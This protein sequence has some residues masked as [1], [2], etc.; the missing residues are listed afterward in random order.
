M[1]LLPEFTDYVRTL[2]ADAT[3]LPE[4]VRARFNLG[5]EDLSVSYQTDFDG[6]PFPKGRIFQILHNVSQYKLFPQSKALNIDYAQ[7]LLSQL[8][9]LCSDLKI[10]SKPWIISYKKLTK[11]FKPEF[12]ELCSRAGFQWNPDVYLGAARGLD[13][14]KEEDI[15]VFGSLFPSDAEVDNSNV[16]SFGSVVDYRHSD[17]Y[18]VWGKHENELVLKEI[19]SEI[20]GTSGWISKM[21]PDRGGSGRKIYSEQLIQAIRSRYMRNKTNVIIFCPYSLADYGIAVH[22][23]FR[24]AT[25]RYPEG[26]SIGVLIDDLK[27]AAEKNEGRLG[28]EMAKKMYMEQ[29]RKPY[30]GTIKAFAQMVN[31]RLNEREFRFTGSEKHNSL[32]LK[33]KTSSKR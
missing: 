12:Q 31:R 11:E 16:S 13:S 29:L 21:R 2:I 6:L 17:T 32:I 4:E 5:E 1:Y 8:K 22:A 7:S 10:Q 9:E 14:M 33:S 3:A 25:E 20:V 15:V 28:F 27:D 30:Q 24:D 18:L 26:F 19:D 23:L